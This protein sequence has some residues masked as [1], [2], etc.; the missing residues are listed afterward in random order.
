MGLLFHAALLLTTRRAHPQLQ[1]SASQSSHRGTSN[2]R[3][4]DRRTLTPTSL[5]LS[6]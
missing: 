2:C 3:I 6:G 4:P 1:T 5:G